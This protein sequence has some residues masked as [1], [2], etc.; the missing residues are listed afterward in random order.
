MYFI[1]EEGFVLYDY[2]N[3]NKV[4]ESVLFS[5]LE[6]LFKVAGECTAAAATSKSVAAVSSGLLAGT[7]GYGAAYGDPLGFD[8]RVGSYNAWMSSFA[9]K[10]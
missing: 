9:R 7:G 3:L 10:Y 4:T 2:I 1:I 5:M 6:G 8:F